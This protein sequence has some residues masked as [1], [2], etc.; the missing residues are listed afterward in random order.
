[1]TNASK[2]LCTHNETYKPQA[3]RAQSDIF[4]TNGESK[5]NWI[6]HTLKKSK[7]EAVLSVVKQLIKKA[8]VIHFATSIERRLW[9]ADFCNKISQLLLRYSLVPLHMTLYSCHFENNNRGID[10]GGDCWWSGCCSDKCQTKKFTFVTAFDYPMILR[11]RLIFMSF[12][13]YNG[14]CSYTVN[15]IIQQLMISER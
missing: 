1:M 15:D 10:S 6:F 4:Y 9:T 5:N 7:L 8:P 11:M 14:T 3:Y 13:I 12:G 2:F